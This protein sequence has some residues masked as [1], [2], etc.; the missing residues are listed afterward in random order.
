[1]KRYKISTPIAYFLSVPLGIA[2]VCLLMGCS[3][4]KKY[5]WQS[6][7]KVPSGY[8]VSVLGGSFY[9]KGPKGKSMFE[10]IGGMGVTEEHEATFPHWYIGGGSSGFSS[11]SKAKLLPQEILIS[12]LSYAEGCEYQLPSTAVD[13]EKIKA[14]FEEGFMYPNFLSSPPL[15]DGYDAIQVGLAP[16]GVVIL[17]VAGMGRAVEVGRYQAE[18]TDV[19]F[20]DEDASRER[21]VYYRKIWRDRVL[22]RTQ[23][24]EKGV[25]RLPIPYGIWDKYRSRYRWKAVLRTQDSHKYIRSILCEYY[26]GEEET[27]FGERTWREDQITK[28]HIPPHL[29]YDYLTDRA[30]P[31]EMGLSWYG[32]DNTRYAVAL[33]FDETEVLDA[34]SKAFAGQEDCSGELIIEVNSSKTNADIFLV[35]GEREIRLTNTYLEVYLHG[36]QER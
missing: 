9:A 3:T 15:R 11:T 4:H 30:I 24:K 33:T 26:N 10:V 14:L 19:D 2:A 35:V 8:P 6:E 28:Y 18:R 13:C 7:V 27:L 16:G 31:H 21:V 12:W 1:M 22:E 32:E 17:W 20:D 36:Y 23:P 29:Q 34:F 5:H 25:S